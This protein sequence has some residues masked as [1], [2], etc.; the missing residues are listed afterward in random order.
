M[1]RIIT[2][3][4]MSYT[5]VNAEIFEEDY[6]L[7]VPEAEKQVDKYA[8]KTMRN[9]VRDLLRSDKGPDLIRQS[10]QDFN[11]GDCL[12][13]PIPADIAE[14]YKI[15]KV[16]QST[17]MKEVNPLRVT[18]SVN[19]DECLI[20]SEIPCLIRIQ[21]DKEDV[22]KTYFGTAYTESGDVYTD[23][24]L[25]IPEGNI[26]SVSLNDGKNFVPLAKSEEEMLSM[27]NTRR[28][29]YYWLCK[30]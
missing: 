9:V 13:A 21:K 16:T 25:E 6:I 27:A 30:D 12:I 22:G 28:D 18:V 29:A 24:P 8:E 4:A 15:E 19:H 17:G 26:M 20:E 2:I 23:E 14:K 5:G 3:Q 10:C 1:K 11:W 7:D